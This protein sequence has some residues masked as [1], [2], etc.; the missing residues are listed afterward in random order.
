MTK[1]D[2]HVIREPARIAAP[3]LVC[4][5]VQEHHRAGRNVYIR[6]ANGKQASALDDLLWTFDQGGFI[7]HHRAGDEQTP[8]PVVIGEN[9]PEN[10]PEILINL[11]PGIPENCQRFPWIVEVV[12]PAHKETQAARERYRR[13]RE[14][15][16]EISTQDV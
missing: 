14:M 1:V 13:Y 2:F 3:M 15:Q 9:L 8:A 5:L 6:A 11:A 7:P 12:D 10:A 16:C 4:R